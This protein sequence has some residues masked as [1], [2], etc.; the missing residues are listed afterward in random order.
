[1]G[2][3]LA[4]IEIQK[5]LAIIDMKTIGIIGLILSIVGLFFGLYCQFQIIPSF[6]ALDTQYDLSKI[7]RAK[8]NSLADLKFLIGSITLFLGA[9]AAVIGLVVGLKKQKIGWVILVLSFISFILGVIQSTH[10]FS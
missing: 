5:Q 4:E 3:I 1:M 2:I 8:W 9:L 6:N 7:E 10:M